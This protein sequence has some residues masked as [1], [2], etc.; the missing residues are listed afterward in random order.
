[1]THALNYVIYK[2][3]REQVSSCRTRFFGVGLGRDPRDIIIIRRR[4]QQ[5]SGFGP[6]QECSAQAWWKEAIRD[7]AALSNGHGSP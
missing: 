4:M 5:I 1:M 3:V 7:E 2:R 6:G